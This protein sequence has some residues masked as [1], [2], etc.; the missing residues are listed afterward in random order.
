MWERNAA[1]RVRCFLN[2]IFT[3]YFY[4]STENVVFDYKF[5]HKRRNGQALPIRQRQ[6]HMFLW[7]RGALGSCQLF[8]DSLVHLHTVC[9]VMSVSSWHPRWQ[10]TFEVSHVERADWEHWMCLISLAEQQRPICL[11]R[12][13][14]DCFPLC[15]SASGEY[16]VVF[17][18]MRSQASPRQSLRWAASDGHLKRTPWTWFLTQTYWKHR[19]TVNWVGG[20]G[21]VLWSWNRAGCSGRA[22]RGALSSVSLCT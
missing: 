12:T 16:L 1:H 11:E 4:K 20:L 21:F 18:N 22:L 8:L 6:S 17:W 9:V 7:L 13:N 5:H 3:K 15:S 10:T 19:R 2:L 14:Q